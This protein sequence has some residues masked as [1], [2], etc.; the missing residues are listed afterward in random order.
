MEEFNITLDDLNLLVV[1]CIGERQ[2]QAGRWSD[3]YKRLEKKLKDLSKKCDK[4]NDYTLGVRI[5]SMPWQELP[6]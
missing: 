6:F 5:D 1:A 4:F 3:E 2:R